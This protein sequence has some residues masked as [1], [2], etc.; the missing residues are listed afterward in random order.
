MKLGSARCDRCGETTL[1]HA[2]TRAIVVAVAQLEPQL[3][4]IDANPETCLTTL[5]AA[6]AE[7]LSWSSPGVR[8]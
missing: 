5:D 3:L 7:V 1:A 4:R 2:N 6:A 8:S